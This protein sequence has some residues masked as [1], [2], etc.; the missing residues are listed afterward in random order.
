M[1]DVFGDKPGAEWPAI[2]V[3]HISSLSRL[4]ICW[5]HIQYNF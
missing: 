4:K 3:F 5:I 1:S 2:V